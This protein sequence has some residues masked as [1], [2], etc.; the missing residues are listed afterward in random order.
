MNIID[1][2]AEQKKYIKEHWGKRGQQK[3]MKDLNIGYKKL[4]KYAKELELNAPQEPAIKESL[5]KNKIKY[6]VENY[7][8]LGAEIIAKH[9]NCGESTIYKYAKRLN[10]TTSCITWSKYEDNFLKK[11]FNTSSIN[12]IR[13]N[14]EKEGYTRTVIAI[15]KRA[16]DLKIKI[17]ITENGFY[18]TSKEISELMGFSIC[19]VNSMIRK[20]FLRGEKYRNKTRTDVRSLKKFLFYYQKYWNYKDVDKEF[21]NLIFLDYDKKFLSKKWLLNKIKQDELSDRRKRKY[22]TTKEIK[23]LKTLVSNNIDTKTICVSYSNKR[24]KTSVSR[25]VFEIKKNQQDNEYI[26]NEK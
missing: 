15:I 20:G 22:W 26:L 2:E 23:S 9:L 25:K 7:K 17:N 11:N 6:I 8:E 13:L 12:K 5:D 18:L 14:L 4:I 21:F 1:I 24:S 10:L 16:K 3:I 19:K